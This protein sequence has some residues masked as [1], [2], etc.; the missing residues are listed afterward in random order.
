MNLSGT[1]YPAA[2]DRVDQV[3]DPIRERR[4][5]V[6]LQQRVGTIDGAG[7][8]DNH[9]MRLQTV[10]DELDAITNAFQIGGNDVSI[11][12]H[13]L[14]VRKT[15]N[16]QEGHGQ[17][18]DMPSIAAGYPNL[19]NGVHRF[20][21][22]DT[23]NYIDLEAPDGILANRKQYLKDVA[24]KVPVEELDG[25]L[26]V[27]SGFKVGGI[28]VVGARQANVVL[29]TDPPVGTSTLNGIGFKKQQEFDD[30][31]AYVGSLRDSLADL[32]NRLVTHGLIEP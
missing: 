16:A 11:P 6:E 24:G 32:L 1:K 23:L 4:L 21:C 9:E 25:T 30:F 7:D 31:V 28:Q 10:E 15:I 3:N 18:L 26:N 17:L 14:S 8:E 13:T 5:I 29:R 22:I 27:D 20:Y 2:I 19:R 12:A